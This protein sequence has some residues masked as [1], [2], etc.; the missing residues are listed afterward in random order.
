[1]MKNFISMNLIINYE[2]IKWFEGE[3]GET[4]AWMVSQQSLREKGVKSFLQDMASSTTIS[5]PVQSD[6]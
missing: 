5:T 4:F 6:I 3:T 1:M 2:K